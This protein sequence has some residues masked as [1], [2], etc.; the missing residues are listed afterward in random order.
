MLFRPCVMV[1]YCLRWE[2]LERDKDTEFS[3]F[4]I[5]DVESSHVAIWFW[6][7]EDVG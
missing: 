7:L 3:A 1:C 6:R 4:E 5:H 2:T